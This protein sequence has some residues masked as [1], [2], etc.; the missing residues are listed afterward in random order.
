M[1]KFEEDNRKFL[2]DTSEQFIA[3]VL[4]LIDDTPDLFLDASFKV[5]VLGGRVC[6]QQDTNC[7]GRFSFTEKRKATS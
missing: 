2:R 4:G 1:H 6:F 5:S 3:R 7:D